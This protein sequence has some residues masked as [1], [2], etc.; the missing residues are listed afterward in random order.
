MII[1]EKNLG[2]MAKKYTYP[3]FN[4]TFNNAQS[5]NLSNRIIRLYL[6]KLFS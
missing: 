5:I 4:Y 1:P 2:F 6:I 3:S